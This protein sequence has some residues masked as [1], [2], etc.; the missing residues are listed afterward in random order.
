MCPA[1]PAVSK[2]PGR[3]PALAFLEDIKASLTRAALED[4]ALAR[5]LSSIPRMPLGARRIAVWLCPCP[6]R[7]GQD[8][9]A[10]LRARGCACRRATFRHSRRAAVTR[11]SPLH[12]EPRAA[13]SPLA[14]FSRLDISLSR[15]H[16]SSTPRLDS[17]RAARRPG[18]C[19]SR[20]EKTDHRRASDVVSCVGGHASYESHPCRWRRGVL[21]SCSGRSRHQALVA[22]ADALQASPDVVEGPTVQTLSSLALGCSTQQCPT[23]ALPPL[24][25]LGMRP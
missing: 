25:M 10:E 14:W 21:A 15:N 23:Q 19:R 20:V 18:C 2:P 24:S 12:V 17:M 11:V 13:P 16:R 6:R 4:P 9:A 1:D 7:Q 5:S 8:C 22:N 3:A